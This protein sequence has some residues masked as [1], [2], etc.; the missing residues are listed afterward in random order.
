MRKTLMIFFLFALGGCSNKAIYDNMQHHNRQACNEVPPSQ[1]E[2]CVERANK[3]Y[4]EYQ[5]ERRAV[6]EGTD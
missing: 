6:V 5:R 4:D 2:D 1:Y 3:S